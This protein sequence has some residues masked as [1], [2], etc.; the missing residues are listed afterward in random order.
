MVKQKK[1]TLVKSAAKAM[2]AD[3]M[4]KG[5]GEL[6]GSED[7]LL[8]RYG[9]SR[10]TLRQA[11]ALLAQEQV[12]LIKRGVNGGYFTR[13]P[14]AK[15]V[16]HTAAIYLQSR[17]TSLQEIIQA[18]LPIKVE[19]ATLASRNRDS[20]SLQR[21]QDLRERDAEAISGDYHAF[22][23]SEAEFG[24]ILGDLA[25]NNVLQLF[26][27]TLYDFCSQLGANE[28]IYRNRPDRVENYWQQRSRMMDAILQGDA[29]L[30][31]MLARRCASLAIQWAV[32]DVGL[33]AAGRPFI[34]A[35]SSDVP[36]IN[37]ARQK[38][39]AGGEVPAAVALAK[40]TSGAGRKLSRGAS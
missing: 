2:R 20:E 27:E 30:A 33:R 10:P 23:K 14:D 1:L 13:R 18:V 36:V 22:L 37:G 4:Q 7:E 19:M 11:S 32:E 15:G 40:K 26:L 3:A 25:G 24:A 16:A 12:L 9:I 38:K 6:L 29:E 31:A 35:E 5:D 28:D 17:H 8:A 39:A 21:L 34:S